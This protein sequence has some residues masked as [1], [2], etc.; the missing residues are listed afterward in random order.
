V[1][2]AVDQSSDAAQQGVNRGDI[3]LSINQ[4]PTPNTQA[5]AAAVAAAQRAG[6]P[7][8]L[9]LLQRGA[10]PPTYVGVKL[11]GK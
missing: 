4:M 11:Q 10:R 5:A 9:L 7:S 2:T 8:V 3:I 1:V 6:R